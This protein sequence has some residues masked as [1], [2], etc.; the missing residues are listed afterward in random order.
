MF[1]PV[2]V[3]LYSITLAKFERSSLRGKRLFCISYLKDFDLLAEEVL[4]L[5]NVLLGDGFDGDHLA[6]FLK[7]QRKR[8]IR[9]ANVDY[10]FVLRN[11][12]FPFPPLFSGSRA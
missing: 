7:R 6:G 3:L 12:P 5:G 10:V 9:F 1:I 4:R 2:C 8:V 11:A